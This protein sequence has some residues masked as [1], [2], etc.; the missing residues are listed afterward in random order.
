MVNDFTMTI[1]T[2]DMLRLLNHGIRN[3]VRSIGEFV[4]PGDCVVRIQYSR[5]TKR[6][7]LVFESGRRIKVVEAQ[8]AADAKFVRGLMETA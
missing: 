6:Y 7:T 4:E 1:T 2:E 3:Y 5:K 8:K